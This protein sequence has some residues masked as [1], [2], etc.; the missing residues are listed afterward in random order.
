LSGCSGITDQGVQSLSSGIKD[1]KVHKA[2]K[3]MLAKSPTMT[4]CS[5]CRR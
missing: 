1:L 2:Y 4:T 5:H 3:G